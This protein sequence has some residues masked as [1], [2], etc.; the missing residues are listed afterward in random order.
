MTLDSKARSAALMHAAKSALLLVDIQ[1]RLL[2]AIAAQETV[3]ANASRLLVGARRLEVPVVAT[4]H[5]P[6]AIG[7]SVAALRQDLDPEKIY[8]KTH[9]SA[10][11]EPDF[12]ARVAAVGRRQWI[13]AGTEAHVCLL[14]TALGLRALDYEVFVVGDAMGSRVEAN[15]QAA[16]VRLQAA[17]CI[18]VTTEMVLFEWLHHAGNAAFKEVLGLIK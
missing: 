11:E 1:E 16:L 6:Q 18:P 10:A 14:Q 3:L 13:L 2:P 17:G 7:T 8:R 4:E 5:C 9:F 15:H 12:V